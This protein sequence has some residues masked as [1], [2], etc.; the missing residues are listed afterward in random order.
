MVKE[1]EKKMKEEKL[2]VKSKAA[3]NAE[4]EEH[5]MQDLVYCYWV[6]LGY[7]EGSIV[8]MGDE[9]TYRCDT[10]G[11]KGVWIPTKSNSPNK[12]K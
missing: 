12:K 7:S 11:N 6:G 4:G 5:A 1:R 8:K 3:P 9:K 10:Q 2:E